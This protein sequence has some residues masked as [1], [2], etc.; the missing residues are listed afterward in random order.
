MFGWLVGWLVGWFAY[1]CCSHLEQRASVKRFVLLQFLNL[2]TFGRNFCHMNFHN[3][4]HTPTGIVNWMRNRSS[5][6]ISEEK[7]TRENGNKW[8]RRSPVTSSYALFR[9][10]SCTKYFC[11]VFKISVVGIQLIMADNGNSSTGSE[12]VTKN[13]IMWNIKLKINLVISN[14]FVTFWSF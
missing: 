8:K 5:E 12:D 6:I 13:L 10:V 9:C 14:F 3:G 7:R 4:A 2:K 11:C 1:S